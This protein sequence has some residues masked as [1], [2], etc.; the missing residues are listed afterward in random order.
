MRRVTAP[1]L[2]LPLP[3]RIGNELWSSDYL[4]RQL[5][6]VKKIARLDYSFTSAGIVRPLT[7]VV[8]SGPDSNAKSNIIPQFWNS[9]FICLQGSAFILT[10][11]CERGRRMP[12]RITV[13]P[14]PCIGRGL[15]ADA[16]R[17]DIMAFIF[18]CRRHCR[19]ESR[20]HEQQLSYRIPATATI[21]LTVYWL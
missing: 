13:R 18:F 14:H 19:P 15:A 2:S 11:Y 9:W 7:T 3:L 21:Q 5:K 8:Q 20:A 17:A 4:R 12:V 6:F 1:G 16:L 10:A